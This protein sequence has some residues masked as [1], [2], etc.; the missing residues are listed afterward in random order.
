MA[1]FNPCK[2]VIVTVYHAFEEYT[3]KY[4]V[5]GLTGENKIDDT[6]TYQQLLGG[7][8]KTLGE[9]YTQLPARTPLPV[10]T[11]TQLPARTPLHSGLGIGGEDEEC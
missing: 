1:A 2:S 3:A 4:N 7:A 11:R 6:K 8:E 10:P 9:L 5:E